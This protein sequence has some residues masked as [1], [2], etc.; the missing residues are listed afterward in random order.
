M[1]KLECPQVQTDRWWLYL[2]LSWLSDKA[3]I[4]NWGEFDKSNPYMKFGSNRV[5]ND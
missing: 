2:W 3:H 5:L 1:A 4:R